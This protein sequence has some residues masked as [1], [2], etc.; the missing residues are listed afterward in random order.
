MRTTWLWVGCAVALGACVN[1]S[2]NDSGSELGG[3]AGSA[4]T[5]SAGSAGQAAVAGSPGMI[6]G[7]AGSLMTMM[8]S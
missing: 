4:L 7:S 8:P 2:T 1:G 3:G 6:A 5:G